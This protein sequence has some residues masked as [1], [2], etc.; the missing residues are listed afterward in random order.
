[1]VDIT[2][3]IAFGLLFALPAWFLWDDRASIGF[4]ALSV[5]ASL[6][7]DIDLWLSRWFPE[8][9]HHH[10]VTHT[11]LVVTIASV[12]VGA[13]LTGLFSTQID[14]RIQS[15]QFD[16]SSLFVFTTLGFLVGGL[17][18]LSADILS[19][20]D[21]ST[22]IEPFWPLYTQPLGIDFV[23]YNAAWINIGFFSVMVVAHIALAYLTTP[24]NHRYRLLP[25]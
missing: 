1:M 6:F 7:P 5:V 2:G 3:H 18:H 11:V 19:A 17:S 20:P 22:P 15:E 23:W 14:N 8:I 9:I 25:K 13:V 16:T 21:I 4:I 12:V 24:I 10:G